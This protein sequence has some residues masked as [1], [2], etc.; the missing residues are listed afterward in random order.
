M[1]KL[2]IILNCFCL[3]WMETTPAYAAAAELDSIKSFL[4]E[5]QMTQKQV[6]IEELYQFSKSK[7]DPAFVK[8]LEKN[9]KSFGKIKVP[10]VT[11][12]KISGPNGEEQ[13]QLQMTQKKESLVMTIVNKGEHFATMSGSYKGKNYSVKVTHQDMANGMAFLDKLAAEVTGESSQPN[14]SS[15]GKEFNLNKVFL[16]YDEIKNMSPEYRA[17]YHKA[18]LNLLEEMDRLGNI[19]AQGQSKTVSLLNILIETANAK[20]SFPC[21]VAGYAG[22]AEDPDFSCRLHDTANSSNAWGGDCQGAVQCNPV[23]YGE[24]VCAPGNPAKRTVPF[25]TTAECN[26]R[27]SSVEKSKGVSAWEY[28]F[29]GKT[30]KNRLDLEATLHPLLAQLDQYRAYCAGGAG[31]LP[32]SSRKKMIKNSEG[33]SESIADQF[34]KTCAAMNSR[35]A[36]IQKV[37]C[38]NFK[39]ADPEKYKNLDCS[40]IKGS[41]GGKTPDPQTP[42][43][44][45]EETDKQCLVLHKE[46]NGIAPGLTCGETNK[47]RLVAQCKDGQLY[48]ECECGS[49]DTKITH[50]KSLVVS[51]EPKVSGEDPS[52]KH[53]PINPKREKERPSWQIFGDA[54]LPLAGG[55][56]GLMLWNYSMKK[57]QQ[58]YYNM[59]AP[60]PTNPL[61]PPPQTPPPSNNTLPGPGAIR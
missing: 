4:Q 38:E 7:L 57:S 23:F 17:K 34:S 58:S 40:A 26:K 42:P 8:E 3:V 30:P 54:T 24:G 15:A 36:D 49:K 44:V 60:S 31:N 27:V 48:M 53:N 13:I 37:D 10:V 9:M 56:V 61:V 11:S 16:G 1:K 19:R 20:S 14:L 46:F 43:K 41:I 35:I 12:T 28:F 59:L 6:T 29:D 50:G 45:E 51:C 5:S 39:Q 18:L 55:L 25:D 52:W 47:P 32:K 2:I 22:V 21:V 33:K